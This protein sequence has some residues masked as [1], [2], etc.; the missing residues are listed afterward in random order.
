MTNNP[1]STSKSLHH[2]EKIEELRAGGHPVP[3]HVQLIISDYCNHDCDFCAYRMSGYT[4]NQMFQEEEGQS[5]SARNPQ[6]QIS[7]DKCIEIIDDCVEM[8]VKCLQFTGGGEPTVHPNFSEI[9]AY[10]QGNGLETSLV[11]NGATL[12]DPEHRAVIKNMA[13]VRVSIDAGLPETY[14]A[15]RGVGTGMWKRVLS[16]LKILCQEIREEEFGCTVGVGFVVTPRNHKEIPLAAQIYKDAGAHN[17]RV[18]LMFNPDGA[19]PF[20]MIRDAIPLFVKEAIDDFADETFSIIDRSSEKLN[21][22]DTGRPTF[23]RCTYQHFTTYIGGDLNVY[24]CC[25]YAYNKRGLVHQESLRNQRFKDLWE[26]S[27]RKQNFDKFNAKSCERCQFTKIIEE[28][29]AAVDQ[30]DPPLQ[31]FLGSKPTHV[32]FV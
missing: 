16:G 5:R 3:V 15:S 21:E 28:I 2:P 32:N 20:A 30:D 14:K 31:S 8:G 12:T 7:F 13:W 29:N 24:R 18:G 22:L 10:A 26:S 19:N 23:T 17:M 9:V 1:Y 27:E 6:R 25:I 11:T 4:S